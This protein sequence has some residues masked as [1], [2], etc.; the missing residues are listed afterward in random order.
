MKAMTIT[1]YFEEGQKPGDATF[2]SMI[3]GGTVTA[4][5]AYDMFE[6]MKIAESA[7]EE[8]D[9]DVCIEAIGKINNVIIQNLN[10]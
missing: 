9:N 1:V 8:I 2:G 3:N 10:E 4:I 6:T 7:L 5:A